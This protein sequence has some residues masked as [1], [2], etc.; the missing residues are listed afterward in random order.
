MGQPNAEGPTI[1]PAAVTSE[2]LVIDVRPDEEYE[3]GHFPGAVSY[4]LDRIRR[5]PD[6]VA[7][8]LPDDREIV[9]Y[10][11]GELCRLAREAAAVLR[12]HGLDAKAMDEGIVEWRATKEVDLGVA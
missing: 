12:E 11:R 2:M 5:Q 4:P 8:E 1:D 7:A 9:L 6:A 10:C 3:A